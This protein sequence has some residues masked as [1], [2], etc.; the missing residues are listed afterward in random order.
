[1]PTEIALTVSI[2]QL[3]PLTFDIIRPPDDIIQPYPLFPVQSYPFEVFPFGG[4]HFTGNETIWG[5]AGGQVGGGGGTGALIVDGKSIKK[6]EMVGGGGKLERERERG[7]L[8]RRST[9]QIKRCS[10]FDL[11]KIRVDKKALP[12]A[13]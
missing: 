7:I 10:H 9:R 5:T 13:N 12:G 2:E 4:G 11:Q 8:N 1:M 6:T 3:R